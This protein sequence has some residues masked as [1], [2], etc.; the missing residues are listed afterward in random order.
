M[1]LQ[2]TPQW[3]GISMQTFQVQNSGTYQLQVW[4]GD[5][6]GT[7]SFRDSSLSSTTLDRSFLNGID[8]RIRQNRQ[9][10]FY[11]SVADG[12]GA[13]VAVQGLNLTLERHAFTFGTAISPE[14]VQQETPA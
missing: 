14:T 13:D 4:L 9:R 1:Q 5:V 6:T 2:L 8:A 10:T 3:Q 7:F 11:L 12:S